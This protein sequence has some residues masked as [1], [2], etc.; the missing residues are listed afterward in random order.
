MGTDPARALELP[1]GRK[2]FNAQLRYQLGPAAPPGTEW[3]PRGAVMNPLHSLPRWEGLQWNPHLPGGKGG[4]D[5]RAPPQ[6]GARPTAPL[7]ES[8]LRPGVSTCTKAIR[9]GGALRG[10]G[11]DEAR[12]SKSL[13]V[14]REAPVGPSRCIPVAKGEPG[15]L[16]GRAPAS[17]LP[18]KTA[19]GGWAR[20]CFRAAEEATGAAGGAPHISRVQTVEPTSQRDMIESLQHREPPATFTDLKRK[21]ATGE[22][23]PNTKPQS[24]GRRNRNA[25]L[26]ALRGRGQPLP[27]GSIVAVAWGCDGVDKICLATLQQPALGRRWPALPRCEQEAP[28]VKIR[29]M[30]P[31]RGAEAAPHAPEMKC[32]SPRATNGSWDDTVSTDAM[33]PFEFKLTAAGLLRKGHALSSQGLLRLCLRHNRGELE[34][35]FRLG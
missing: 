21:R 27:K 13:A 28:K 33:C 34:A 11:I 19:A 20:P 15:A 29:W 10:L 14:W 17:C 32:Y 30:W 26:A 9:P 8:R 16:I 3:L 25:E 31:N 6:P 23:G 24:R 5:D 2:I 12:L 1:S 35:N 7:T 22:A 18:A 4:P